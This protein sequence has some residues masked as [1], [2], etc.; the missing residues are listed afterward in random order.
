MND[1]DKHT[2]SVVS[3][4]VCPWCYIGKNRLAKAFDILANETPAALTAV[5]IEWLPFELN[6]GLP[7]AGMDRRDYCRMKFGS[8]DYAN[9]LYA[10]VADNARAD[11][12]EINLDRISVT[13]NS[14]Q[15]HRLIYFASKQSL[16]DAA[17]AELFRAY[18]VNGEN[19]G[20]PQ[21]LG[22]LAVRV[23]LDRK[24]TLDFLLADDDSGEFQALIERA[25]D[26][27]AQGVPAFLWDGV[28]LFTGAQSPETI[29][30][31][32]KQQIE[33]AV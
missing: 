29:A 12:L 16:A 17:V 24:S 33:K 2:I 22:E 27:G 23:G 15:A 28:W 25:Y 13:P 26:S 4:V 5:T 31:V 20:D 6:P 8:L 9:K 11:G 7:P 14:R 30:L 19:I 3:D 18:F 10:N 32:I 21:I 1:S